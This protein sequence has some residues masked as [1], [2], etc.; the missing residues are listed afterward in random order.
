M[1]TTEQTPFILDCGSKQSRPATYEQYE[2]LRRFDNVEINCNVSSFTSRISR[3]D[4]SNA[5][6]EAKQGRR[7]IINR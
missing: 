4:A 3:V 6:N 2:L 1:A 5:I 7:V